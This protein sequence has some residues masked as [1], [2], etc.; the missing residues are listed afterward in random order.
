MNTTL[1]KFLTLAGS[2]LLISSYAQGA[3]LLTNGSFEDDAPGTAVPTGW[4]VVQTADVVKD[5]KRRVLIL[6][7]LITLEH[8]ME[9]KFSSCRIPVEPRE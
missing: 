5:L 4:T 8:R 6:Q 1:K 2:S 7:F 3:S 9:I